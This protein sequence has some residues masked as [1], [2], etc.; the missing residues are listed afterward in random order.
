MKLHHTSKVC[1]YCNANLVGE[2]I[3]LES[4]EAYGDTHFSRLIG[5]ELSYDHPDHYDGVSFWKCP[6]CGTEDSVF[7]SPD[8]I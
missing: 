7:S 8:L 5:I 3:P 2:P 6:D 1:P 4:Q